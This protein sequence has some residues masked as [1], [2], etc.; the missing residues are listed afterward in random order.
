MITNNHTTN[1]NIQKQSQLITEQ[2]TPELLPLDR[3]FRHHGVKISTSDGYAHSQPTITYKHNKYNDLSAKVIEG[4][5]LHQCEFSV[6]Y[7]YFNNSYIP[8]TIKTRDNITTVIDKIRSDIKEPHVLIR[9]EITLK[10]SA[11]N[12]LISYLSAIDITINE[13]ELSILKQEL[14]NLTNNAIATV[15]IDYIIPI[16]ELDK[17]RVHNF[18][19]SVYVQEADV[20]ISALDMFECPEHP[21][22]AKIINRFYFGKCIEQTLEFNNKDTYCIYRYISKNIDARPIYLF[23]GY[24]LLKLIPV[25]DEIDNHKAKEVLEVSYTARNYVEDGKVDVTGIR[26]SVYSLEEAKQLFIIMDHPDDLEYKIAN[27]E[28]A[29]K[30]LILLQQKLNTSK[31]ILSEKEQELE[32]MKLDIAEKNLLSKQLDEERSKREKLEEEHEIRIEKQ[33]K[34][35]KEEYEYKFKLEKERLQGNREKRKDN[36]DLI[37]SGLALIGS[38]LGIFMLYSKAKK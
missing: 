33:E 2:F 11:L 26:R 32:N 24:A 16:K 8:V 20:V 14:A 4:E 18:I 30:E 37:K 21:M 13:Q 9:K 17:N 27:E 38:V 34:K 5:N 15:H 1:Q 19:R 6:K 28:K 29:K 25:V 10:G 23:D 35:I 22:S 3:R 7:F 31:I 36:M 12:N